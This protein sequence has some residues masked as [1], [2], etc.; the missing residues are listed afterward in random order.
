MKGLNVRQVAR[1]TRPFSRHRS[2][3]HASIVLVE[4][5]SLIGTTPDATTPSAKQILQTIIS[6]A[7]F[8]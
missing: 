8:A 3:T 6:A 4:R 5:V 2:Q 1:V 7:Q